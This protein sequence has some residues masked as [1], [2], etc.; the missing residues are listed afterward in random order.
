M[1]LL[2]QDI[3]GQKMPIHAKHIHII[4]S[5][6]I[7]VLYNDLTV[8]ADFRSADDCQSQYKKMLK[9]KF[10]TPIVLCEK[11]GFLMKT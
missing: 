4:K 7:S 6:M 8:F 5:Q 3:N 1:H 2:L 9:S 10:R 11:F